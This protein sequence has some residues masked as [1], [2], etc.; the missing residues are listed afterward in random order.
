MLHRIKI[1]Q[2]RAVRAVN[3]KNF[4]S[5]SDPIYS[6]LKILKFDN[7]HTLAI[8]ILMHNYYNKL[9]PSFENMFIPLLDPNWTKPHKLEKVDNTY[10][11]NKRRN[12][13]S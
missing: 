7:I 8:L 6:Q 11:E 1:L 2:R 12:K 9:P 3:N 4:R 13:I 10:L 5:H